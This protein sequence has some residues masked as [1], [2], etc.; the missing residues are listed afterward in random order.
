MAQVSDSG[1]VSVGGRQPSRVEAQP[2]RIKSPWIVGPWIDVA[3]IVASPIVVIATL[4]LARGIWSGTAIS[5]FVM[6]WA[7][8]H[9]LPGMMRVR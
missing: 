4:T 7:I 8:G 5:A 9:H 6:I 1:S 3:L 2:E